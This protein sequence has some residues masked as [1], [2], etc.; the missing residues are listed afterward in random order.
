[1]ANQNYL[2]K[3]SD[4][5]TVAHLTD[6]TIYDDGTN[7]NVAAQTLAIPGDLRLRE[8]GGGVAFLQARDDSS[9][10]DI[11]LRLRTQMAGVS[12]PSITEAVTINNKGNMGVGADATDPKGLLQLAT[13]YV[14]APPPTD[15]KNQDYANIM[16]AIEAVHNSIPEAQNGTDKWGTVSLQAGCYRLGQNQTLDLSNKNGLKL[17]GAGMGSTI[18]IMDNS[19][20]Q[21]QNVIN[22]GGGFDIT[23]KDMAILSEQP[24]IHTGIRITGP[25]GR[26][27][28]ENIYIGD[29][30]GE[31]DQGTGGMAT[32]ILLTGGTYNNTFKHTPIFFGNTGIQIGETGSGNLASCNR[33]YGGQVNGCTNYGVNFVQGCTNLLSGF[34]I[35]GC[36]TAGDNYAGVRF[37]NGD[38]NYNGNTI[39]SC[40]LEYNPSNP[41]YHPSLIL[42]D[43]GTKNNKIIGCYLYHI[44]ETYLINWV[45]GTF[46]NVALG[47][48]FCWGSG[49]TEGSTLNLGDTY[50]KISGVFHSGLIFQTYYDSNDPANAFRWNSQDA[51]KNVYNLMTLNG[52]Q[53]I[54]WNRNHFACK[55]A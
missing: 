16:A 1:M 28:V 50:Q 26:H 31:P 21:G 52:D 19:S 25:G 12:A 46:G 27:N 41:N 47:N 9:N 3:S 38:Q 29:R 8:Y 44:Q 32:G 22:I 43:S 39:E 10:R 23:I 42:L 34:D 33:F 24:N 11:G 7:L 18:I 2:Q 36:G 35:E 48:T 4:G 15:D 51:N 53:W 45:Q 37:G 49:N 55:Q 17:I 54:P 40:Y 5:N 14:V 30:Y 6:S 13:S 20:G